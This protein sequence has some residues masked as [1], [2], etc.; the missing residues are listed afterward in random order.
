[1]NDLTTSEVGRLMI[2][3]SDPATTEEQKEIY[4][5]KVL[6]V[7]NVQENTIKA[8]GNTIKAQGNTIKA[9]GNTINV[10]GNTINVQ[11][12]TIKAQTMYYFPE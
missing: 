10:Q 2:A 4:R 6:N 3:I 8:Q 12:N 1:M 7:I 5:S 11:E 9:Q